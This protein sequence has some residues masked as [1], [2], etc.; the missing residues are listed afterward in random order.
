[1]S[2]LIADLPRL[3][4]YYNAILLI[5]SA[6]ITLA[7]TIAGCVIGLIFGFVIAAI[8]RTRNV[9]LLPLRLLLML[10]VELFRRVPFIVTLFLVLFMS[11]GAGYNLPL[12][13]IA[14]IAVCI[15][16]TSYLAEVFRAGFG[17]VPRLQIE[18]AEAM[19][20]SAA[21][22]LFSI[23]LPQAWRVVLP[24]AVAFMV[25]LVK[26]T[27]LASQIGVIELTFAGK[28][29]ITRGYASLPVYGVVLIGYFLMS[30]PLAR[31][32][33]HLEQRLSHPLRR[34]LVLQPGAA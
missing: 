33:A 4:T 30:F 3:F 2:G 29:L 1:M 28:I 9:L 13:L 6:G 27:A 11:Q 14:L 15:I 34:S 21:R 17:S 25:S 19:N 12:F 23:I 18:A 31:F 16:A 24:A 20:F 26:D 22:I 10:L 8:R 32:G 7:L 5:N